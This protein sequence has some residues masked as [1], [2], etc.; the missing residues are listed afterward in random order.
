MNA[1]RSIV[2]FFLVVPPVP[3]L[4]PWT[5]AAAT[6]SG[7][8]L[9]AGNHGI[10][11]VMPPI[12][13][14]QLFSAS[15]GF[16]VSSRRGYYDV[17][18]TRGESRL[19][20]AGVHWASSIA[21]GVA[22]WLVLELSMLAL[23][24]DHPDSFA[25]GTILALGIVSTMPWALTVGRPRFS[26]AIGWIVLLACIAPIEHSGAPEPVAA[27]VY[28]PALLGVDLATRPG[29]GAAPMAVVAIAMAA[30]GRWIHV[31]DIPLEASQ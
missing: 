24:P 11:D 4:L 23:R 29:I 25:T 14:L 17:L 7:V 10:A 3:S 30:A 12:L 26:A 31:A 9:L 6:L 19:T 20:V 5:F 27:L 15:S 8:V 21:P 2:S 1:I 22:A 13:L 28:P 16:S 18:L